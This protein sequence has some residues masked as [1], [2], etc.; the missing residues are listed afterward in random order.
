MLQ[1]LR[2]VDAAV[3][4][5]C[6]RCNCFDGWTLQWVPCA[7]ALQF[8]LN[9]HALTARVPFC[10]PVYEPT[11]AAARSPSSAHTLIY[12]QIGGHACMHAS[13]PPVPFPC[14]LPHARRWCKPWRPS[15]STP[16]PQCPSHARFAMR[17]GGASHGAPHAGRGPPHPS[18]ARAVCARG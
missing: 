4:S 3:G 16:C 5:M 7:G 14:A 13:T 18:G 9:L 6:G 12:S 8:V 15:R 17:A 1:L 2:W 11:C 10:T